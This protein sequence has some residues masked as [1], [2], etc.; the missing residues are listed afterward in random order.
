[1]PPSFLPQSN[2]P[3]ISARFQTLERLFI[4]AYNAMGRMISNHTQDTHYFTQTLHTKCHDQ[5]H[6]HTHWRI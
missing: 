4:H 2:P 3:Q 5:L 6:T 1:M